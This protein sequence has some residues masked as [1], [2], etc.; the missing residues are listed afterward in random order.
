MGVASEVFVYIL[1]TNYGT[2]YTGI[3]N[4]IERRLKEHKEGKSIYMRG[5]VIVN[6]WIV[7]SCETRRDAAKLERKIKRIG[8]KKYLL[9]SRYKWQQ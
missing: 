9:K 1:L 7:E 6:Y 5:K 2:F 8:A 4:D 3:T